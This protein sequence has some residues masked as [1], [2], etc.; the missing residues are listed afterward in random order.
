[1]FARPRRL[2]PNRLKSARQEFEHMLQLGIIRPLSSAWSSPLHCKALLSFQSCIW[3]ELT[4][5]YWLSLCMHRKLPSQ[6]YSASLNS[7]GCLLGYEMQHKLF[8][9]SWT[10]SCKVCISHTTTTSDNNS[11]ITERIRTNVMPKYFSK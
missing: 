11:P 8:S 1:M 5:K 10:Q 4:T 2:A 6:L 9:D 7:Y 3:R